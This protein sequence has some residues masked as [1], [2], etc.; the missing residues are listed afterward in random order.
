MNV[1][2]NKKFNTE[3]INRIVDENDAFVTCNKIKYSDEY[4]DQNSLMV[5]E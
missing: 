3:Q 5:K 4:I 2:E 1:E